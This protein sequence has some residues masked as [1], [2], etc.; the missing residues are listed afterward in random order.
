MPTPND[1][2]DD[3]RDTSPKGIARRLRRTAELVERAH[4]RLEK[5]RGVFAD[6]PDPDK[7]AI[8]SALN[9]IVAQSAATTKLANELLTRTR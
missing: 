3:D 8:I 2:D 1:D 9:S 5:I 7:P 4:Q 6:P